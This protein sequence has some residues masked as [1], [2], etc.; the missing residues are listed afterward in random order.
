KFW[1][2]QTDADQFGVVPQ[3]EDISLIDYLEDHSQLVVLYT[4]KDGTQGSAEVR[5]EDI[6]DETLNACRYSISAQRQINQKNKNS[7][8]PFFDVFEYKELKEMDRDKS[9][10]PVSSRLSK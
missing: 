2:I 8:D 1:L 3:A 5:T 9:L 6:L 4:L 10:K 7:L